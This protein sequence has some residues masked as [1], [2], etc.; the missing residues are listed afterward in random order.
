MGNKRALERLI[1]GSALLFIVAPAVT[2]LSLKDVLAR[3]DET[4]AVRSAR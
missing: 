2:S 3:L 1:F 4:Y